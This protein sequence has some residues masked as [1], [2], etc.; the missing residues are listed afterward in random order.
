MHARAAHLLLSEAT[1]LWRNET[2]RQGCETEQKSKGIGYLSLV[3]H[4][5]THTFGGPFLRLPLPVAYIRSGAFVETGAHPW[6]SDPMA[7]SEARLTRGCRPRRLKAYASE[8]QVQSQPQENSP[9]AA[10]AP[11]ALRTAGD[12]CSLSGP[13]ETQKRLHPISY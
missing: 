9:A 4:V 7:F 8:V 12:Q 2:E 13:V 10:S 6:A 3:V 5:H 11:G 1:F